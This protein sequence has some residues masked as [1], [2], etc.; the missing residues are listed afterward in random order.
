M[1]VSTQLTPLQQLLQRSAD[2][3]L[4]I[5]AFLTRGQSGSDFLMRRVLERLEDSLTDSFQFIELAERAAE[6]LQ[7]ELK[8]TKNPV[9][10]L[11]DR[12]EIQLL[13]SGMMPYESLR[14]VLE[15]YLAKSC[16]PL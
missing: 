15:S 10:L 7:K 4:P 3:P 6:G 16:Q 11:L 12:S 9:V 2:S 5:V 1:T 14:E 8:T 13:F